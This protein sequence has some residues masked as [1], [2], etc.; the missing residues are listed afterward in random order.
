MFKKLNPFILIQS[1]FWFTAFSSS[2]WEKFH[3]PQ[4]NSAG[5]FATL[6]LL[7]IVSF[8]GNWIFL[9]NFFQ[10]FSFLLNKINKFVEIKKSSKELSTLYFHLTS[11]HTRISTNSSNSPIYFLFWPPK[12][13]IL[14]QIWW[15]IWW[16]I[17]TS[18]HQTK[19]I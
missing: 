14:S 12:T 9:G 5:Q 8:L 15:I 7:E 3:A 6:T 4:N 19:Q 16:R 11:H 18:K 13:K 1:T 10:F 2:A 17:A